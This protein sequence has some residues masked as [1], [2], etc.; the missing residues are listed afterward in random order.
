MQCTESNKNENKCI[1]NWI[2]VGFE[3]T[4][5]PMYQ[6]HTKIFSSNLVSVK[7]LL[8]T[9]RLLMFQK[10]IEFDLREISL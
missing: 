3:I 7:I 5:M 6:K 2:F 8:F 1:L 4:K 10:V 9:T